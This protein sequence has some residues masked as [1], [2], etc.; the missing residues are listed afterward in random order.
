[1]LECNGASRVFFVPTY[2]SFGERI[3]KNLVAK[4][5]IRYTGSFVKAHTRVSKGTF[6]I[7]VYP[8]ISIRIWIGRATRDE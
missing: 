5:K 6:Y 3:M 8:R 2:H 4:Q 1:M 7:G